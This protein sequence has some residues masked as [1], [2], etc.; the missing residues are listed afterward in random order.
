MAIEPSEMP[1]RQW[2]RRVLRYV[3]GGIDDETHA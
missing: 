1:H 3:I 2:L